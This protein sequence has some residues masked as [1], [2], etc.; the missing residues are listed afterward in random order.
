VKAADG[1]EVS[2]SMKGRRIELNFP[3][4]E[5]F[6]SVEPPQLS[7]SFDPRRI[8]ALIKG[9]RDKIGADVSQNSIVM[10]RDRMPR[11]WEE[12]L[13]AKLGKILWI[14]STE[15]DFPIQDVSPEDR[16]ITRPDLIGHETEGGTPLHVVSSKLGSILWE[17]LKK[18]IYAELF[19][20]I[21]YNEYVVGYV[22]LANTVEKHTR[23]TAQLVDYVHQ[24][25]KILC[26][27]LV[28]NGYFS[29][30][31]ASDR[32]FEAPIIDISASGLLFAHPSDDLARE[33]HIHA[34]LDLAL[35]ISKRTIN[36]S[37]RIMRKLKDAHN[38]YFGVIF[39]TMAPED[40]RF[41]FEFLYGKP[42]AA[43][44]EMSWE[45]GSPPPA[46]EL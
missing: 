33:L 1:V 22:Y 11:S 2:F 4:S 8:N 21:L 16:I 42:F 41:L 7:E 17:K 19:C 6:A 23:I 46:L 39:M 34:D 18:G 45:G 24:F 3:K 15:E 12:K 20:P 26:Y 36:T 38:S 25:S 30:E 31:A 27:S 5:H 13:V 29:A 37:A 43:K 32:R 14:P 28:A 10:F 44:Y 9:F 40:F 35:K